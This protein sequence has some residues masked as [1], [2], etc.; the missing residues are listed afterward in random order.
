[1]FYTIFTTMFA[2][3]LK[4]RIGAFLALL[5]AAS[6]LWPSG[7]CPGGGCDMERHVE[8]HAPKKSPGHCDAHRS[9]T[10]T[11][12]GSIA[13]PPTHEGCNSMG[14]CY[15]LG[16][17]ESENPILAAPGELLVIERVEKIQPPWLGVQKYPTDN[18]TM[19]FAPSWAGAGTIG[20]SRSSQ[21]LSWSNS[22]S[23]HS[24]SH[25]IYLSLLT[26]LI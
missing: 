26:L 20:L 13:Q 24:R 1:M 25:P 5:L 4:Q 19:A 2:L 15:L 7:V 10:A 17:L 21:I 8:T 9:E 22:L 23:S 18:F 16:E 14:R 12:L 3:G 11:S 6:A